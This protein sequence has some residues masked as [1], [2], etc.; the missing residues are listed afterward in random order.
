MV[1]LGTLKRSRERDVRRL[2]AWLGVH[3]AS[4]LPMETLVFWIYDRLT[5]KDDRWRTGK[6]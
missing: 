2:G 6:V 3:G 1:G 5:R 4:W